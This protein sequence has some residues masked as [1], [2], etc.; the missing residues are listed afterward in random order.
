MKALINMILVLV[1]CVSLDPALAQPP[2]AAQEDSSV[3]DAVKQREHEWAEAMT[4][5][6]FDKL[7]QI[8]ADDFVDGYPGKVTTKA[9]FLD[10]VRS[11]KHKLESYEYG[12]V[13][14]K[15]LGNVAVVQGSITETRITDGQ[16]HTVHVAFMDVFA[17]RGENWVV[18]RGQAH[19]L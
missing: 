11:G 5:V 6:N 9:G 16:P 3:A 2:K 7:N 10:D 15:V 1:G 8:I 13:D 19:R 17:K 18:V 12:P 14:V 4:A